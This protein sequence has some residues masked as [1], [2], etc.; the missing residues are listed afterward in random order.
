[1]D[2]RGFTL[3]ETLTGVVL[4]IVLAGI[5]TPRLSHLAADYRL[6]VFSRQLAFEITRTRAQAIAQHRYARLRIAGY[7]GTQQYWVET[8]TDGVAYTKQGDPASIPASVYAA[9]PGGVFPTFDRQG[10]AAYEVDILLSNQN[11]RSKTVHVNR[12]GRVTV[13]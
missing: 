11:G 3:A 4:A 10:F 9:L 2:S 13:L 7:P 12:I 6:A 5:A 8:S 1:M